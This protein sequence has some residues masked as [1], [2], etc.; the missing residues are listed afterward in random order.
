MLKNISPILSPELLKILCEMGHG[1]ELVLGDG[2]FPHASMATN[3]LVR[4]DG[5]G[6][7]EIL[8]AILSLFPLDHASE[9]VVSVMA[10]DDG[11]TPPIWA[12][13][14]NTVDKYEKAI[15]FSKVERFAFYERAKSAYCI[16]ATSEPKLYANIILKKGCVVNE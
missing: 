5:H 11:T 3:Q 4:L 1:D 16:V 8:D 6:C 14:K 9:T 7:D 10:T 15:E 12:E 13:Y 2:N